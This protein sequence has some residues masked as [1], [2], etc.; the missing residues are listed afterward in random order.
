MFD[1]LNGPKEHGKLLHYR[2]GLV[3]FHKLLP[4][5]QGAFLF[6]INNNFSFHTYPFIKYLDIVFSNRACFPE[7]II[8]ETKSKF[9]LIPKTW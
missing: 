1:S 8:H 3:S 5:E 7:I 9:F 6:T 2:I 4:H